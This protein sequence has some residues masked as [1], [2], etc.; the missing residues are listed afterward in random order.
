MTLPY[1]PVQN[2]EGGDDVMF[3]IAFATAL[4]HHQNPVHV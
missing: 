1:E 3:S 4:A 2:Q